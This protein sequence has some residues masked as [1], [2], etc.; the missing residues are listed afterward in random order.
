MLLPLSSK[1]R[2]KSGKE[3]LWEESSV[4]TEGERLGGSNAWPQVHKMGRAFCR[5]K[6]DGDRWN[7]LRNR[8]I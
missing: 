8:N 6:E 5:E 4:V 2:S 3:F 1:E 7:D